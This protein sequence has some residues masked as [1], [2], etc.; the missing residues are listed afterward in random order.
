MVR[1]K[2]CRL[3]ALIMRWRYSSLSRFFISG[4]S[5]PVW[6]STGC[7]R[8]GWAGRLSSPLGKSTCHRNDNVSSLFCSLD[9]P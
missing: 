1:Q 7:S 3:V 6:L 4:Y 8:V 2:S 9:P 5:S